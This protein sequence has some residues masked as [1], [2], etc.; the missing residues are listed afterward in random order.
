MHDP[1]AL[2][3]GNYSLPAVLLTIILRPN[4]VQLGPAAA[5]RV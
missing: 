2:I 3:L 1:P 5:L 4:Q